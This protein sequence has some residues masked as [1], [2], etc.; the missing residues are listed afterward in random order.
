MTQINSQQQQQQQQQQSEDEPPFAANNNSTTA[1]SEAPRAQFGQVVDLKNRR[2]T[3]RTTA[4]EASS[5]SSATASPAEAA[6]TGGNNGDED[7]GLSLV[8]QE[9]RTKNIAVAVGSVLLALLNFGWQ[10]AHPNGNAGARM[11]A[12]MQQTSLPVSVIGRNGKPSVVD[13]WAPWCETCQ[14]SAPTLR[15][16]ES[17]PQYQQKVNFIMVNGDDL[18][19]NYDAIEQ[20]GVDAIPHLA[21][22]DESGNVLTALIGPVPKHIMEADID[23]LVAN[24]NA[25]TAASSNNNNNDNGEGISSSTTTTSSSSNEQPKRS[26]L[27]YVM[28]DVF[29]NRPDQRRVHFPE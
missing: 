20:F 29:A 18:A 12:D 24:A 1:A 16:V 19:Q 25:A 5:I 10:Y 13:F 23:V 7:D 6:A 11:L 17:N 4:G 3:P 28:L 21:M 22:V 2:I 8:L 27:P 14:Q 15:A 26:N 9:R